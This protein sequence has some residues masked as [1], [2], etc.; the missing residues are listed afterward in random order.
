[1]PS[2]CVNKDF[3][4][5]LNRCHDVATRKEYV[6]LVDSVR[7]SGGEVKIFSSMHVSGERK[8]M[9]RSNL[10]SVLIIYTFFSFQSSLN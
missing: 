7:D 10:R 1:M 2:L 8:L 5:Q 9:F 4:F 6:L 3:T